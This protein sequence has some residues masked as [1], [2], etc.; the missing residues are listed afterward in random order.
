MNQ[1]IGPESLSPESCRADKE[2]MSY[3][4]TTTG[5]NPKYNG[6]QKRVRM[7]NDP[8]ERDTQ[9]AIETLRRWVKV[10]VYQVKSNG[11]R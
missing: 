3:E 8:D 2:E 5:R 9:R 4:I 10:N 7:S 1:K 6:V 11:K